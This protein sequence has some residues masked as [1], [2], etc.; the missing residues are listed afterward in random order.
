MAKSAEPVG[1][2]RLV[3]SR[4]VRL[5][6]I[7]GIAVLAVIVLRSAL[8]LVLFIITSIR[9]GTLG[10]GNFQSEVLPI[11]VLAAIAGISSFGIYKLVEVL[12]K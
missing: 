6:I 10:T 9:D 8:A 5:L 2:K 1:H 7:L 4:G 12:R 11:I 3:S